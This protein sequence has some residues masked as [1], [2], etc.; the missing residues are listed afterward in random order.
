MDVSEDSDIEEE[1]KDIDENY[2]SPFVSD[3]DQE[4]NTDVKMECEVKKG[5]VNL[6]MI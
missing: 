1:I 6:F 4:D 3:P 5:R 2:R